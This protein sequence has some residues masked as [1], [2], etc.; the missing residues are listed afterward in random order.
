MV[1]NYSLQKKII[2]FFADWSKLIALIIVTLLSIYFSQQPVEQQGELQRYLNGF[3]QWLPL[4]VLIWMARVEVELKNDFSSRTQDLQTELENL[5]NRR[6]DTLYREINENEQMLV[7][8][9]NR[10]LRF[11]DDDDLDQALREILKYYSEIKILNDLK[12]SEH[13]KRSIKKAKKILEQREFTIKFGE[14]MAYPGP[15]YECSYNKEIVATNIG[16][17]SQGFWSG[18]K[19]RE[20]LINLNDAIISKRKEINDNLRIRRIFVLEQED[21]TAELTDLMQRFHNIGVEVRYLSFSEANDLACANSN[22][23]INKLE[24]F[25]VFNTESNEFPSYSGRLVDIKPQKK[26]II[27]S[28]PQIIEGL[29]KQFEVLW[30]RAHEYS[31]NIDRS[32]FS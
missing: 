15:F 22:G 21:I 24:D 27:S 16:S 10:F 11:L 4:T 6:F 3:A 26:M 12:V 28:N 14:V 32:I 25:T 9:W 19:D 2:R 18:L 1:E 5:I 30:S 20:S 29:I 8:L 23:T 13:A 17:I 31:G 7:Q